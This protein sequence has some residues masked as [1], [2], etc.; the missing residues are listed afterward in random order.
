MAVLAYLPKLKG[1]LRL[2]FGV[3]SVWFLPAGTKGGK[4]RIAKI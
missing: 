2:G 1:D 3:F 4:D